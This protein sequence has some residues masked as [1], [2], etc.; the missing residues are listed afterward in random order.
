[1]DQVRTH[2][3]SPREERRAVS[4][5]AIALGPKRDSDVVVSDLSYAGCRLQSAD[6]FKPGELVELRVFNR[7]LVQAEVRWTRDD[8]AGARFV[9]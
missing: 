8:R 4:L 1:M 3:F 7:G 9:N 5:R 2:I 6:A